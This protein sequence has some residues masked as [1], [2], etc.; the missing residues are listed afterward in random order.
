MQQHYV[1]KKL[2]DFSA[3]A[4]NLVKM[5]DYPSVILMTGE[6]GVGK[7]TLT[8]AIAYKLG[9]SQIVNSPTFVIA[10]KYNI[11]NNHDLV[12]YDFYRLQSM[13]DLTEIGFWESLKNNIVIIE[14][15]NKIH[16]FKKTLLKLY[17]HHIIKI[18]LKHNYDTKYREI[19]IEYEE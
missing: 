15:P 8:K 14:W 7:T 2:S 18:S 17:N 1:I 12:H 19:S 5:I 11:D 3:I 4:D 9:I 10:K 6:L 16:D 13:N